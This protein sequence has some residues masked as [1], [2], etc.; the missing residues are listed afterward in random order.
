MNT[1]P[2]KVLIAGAL[3]QDGAYLCE[4]ALRHGCTVVGGVRTLA[5]ANGDRAW[6][7]GHLGIAERVLLAEMDMADAGS[8]E[9]ALRA[10]QPDTVFNLAAQSSVARSFESPLETAAA[11]GMG[12]VHLF[13]SARRSP[14]PIR[15]VQATSA[16]IVSGAPDGP[17]NGTS[18]YGA[19]KAFAHLMARVYRESLGTFVSSAVLYNHE[20]PLRGREFVSRKIIAALVS[21]R[22]GKQDQL[23]LGNLAARRDWSHARD[24]VE[25]LWQIGAAARAGE[26]ALGSGES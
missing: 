15:V 2:A 4:L 3:G 22:A 25:G 12:A 20:S 8:I 24:I 13:E 16:D 6:R 10:H 21:I 26:F 7:L 23:L 1:P 14:R 11:N 9:A 19:A 18:P 5:Q 17:V